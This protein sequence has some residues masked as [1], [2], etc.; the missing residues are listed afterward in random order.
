MVCVLLTT[1]NWLPWQ[2]PLRNRKNW[3]RLRKFMQIPSI[4]WKDRENRSSRYWDSLLIVKKRYSPVGRFAERAKS[5]TITYHSCHCRALKCSYLEVLFF[6]WH[7]IAVI[8]SIRCAYTIGISLFWMVLAWF[9]PCFWKKHSLILLAISWGIVVWFSPL[10][11]L[12]ERAIYCTLR[13]FFLFYLFLSFL[14]ISRR[15][16]ISRSMDRFS[17]SLRRM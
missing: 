16:I 10:G 8:S 5:P 1:Q 3:T 12:A 11:K 14:M 4:W 2:R 13:N 17:Q 9:T 15:Q 6:F 7:L